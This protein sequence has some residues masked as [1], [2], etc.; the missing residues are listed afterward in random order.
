VTKRLVLGIVLA[1]TASIAFV[2]GAGAGNFDE[3][4]MGCVGDNPA[5]CPAGTVGQPYSLKLYLLG[6]EDLG[7][8]VYT[9][10]GGHPPG[11]SVSSEGFLSGTPTQAGRFD[12]YL[13]VD[14][15]GCGKPASDDRFI[16][17][18][19]P[20][21]PALPALT[22]GPGTAPVGTVN[23]PY[24]LQMTANLSD[25]KAWSIVSGALPPGLA[26][27]AST[28]LISGTLQTAGTYG[29][30][31]QATIDAQRTAAQALTIVV[32]DPVAIV[33]P[34]LEV[35]TP[36]GDPALEVG[37]PF[38]LQLSAAGGTGTYSWSLVGAL[39]TGLTFDPATVSVSGQ[40]TLRGRWGF[41]I[42]VA[43]T[44]GRLARYT[45]V[46]A[47]SARLGI[48]TKLLRRGRVGR[49]YEAKLKTTGG[50]AP[51]IWKVLRGPLPRGLRLDRRLGLVYGSPRRQGIYGVTFEVTD[52]L[53]V[54]SSTRLV[55]EIRSPL[56]S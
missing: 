50:I 43:D 7:C 36:S 11:L 19:N 10:S 33:E 38:S 52:A 44:E 15:P 29:F 13:T 49:L 25:P 26:I 12:F 42:S 37:V 20:G 48:S 45:A 41:T 32:R 30:T 5:T 34:E 18:I 8:A 14:Y 2:P 40:P 46:L 47:V 24:S 1:L 54:R 56:P 21:R 4:R 6:D 53:G 27:D 22:I 31:V 39:P 23:V 35:T 28:G 3:E 51:R 17:E 9:S 16:I 55:V